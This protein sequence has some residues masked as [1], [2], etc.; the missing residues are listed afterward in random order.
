[1]KAGDTRSLQCVVTLDVW[2]R[3]QQPGKV[4]NV[5]CAHADDPPAR[6]YNVGTHYVPTLRN[7]VSPQ[8]HERRYEKFAV[9]TFSGED[10]CCLK[11]TR[12]QWRTKHEQKR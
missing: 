12:R 3:R 1:M 2:G 7:Y 6:I 10:H 5:V 11:L 9:S 8:D 4:G